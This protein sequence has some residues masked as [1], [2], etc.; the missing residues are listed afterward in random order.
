M[1]L[2]YVIEMSFDWHME[3]GRF[4]NNH[5]SKVTLFQVLMG[6]QSMEHL[7]RQSK[8]QI[9]VS[10]F[11]VGQYLVYNCTVPIELP[12]QQHVLE[13]NSKRTL[14]WTEIHRIWHL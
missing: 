13:L 11:I 2:N 12:C 4:K 7:L 9:F 14:C 1:D 10:V 5:L 8:S 3:P 6:Y